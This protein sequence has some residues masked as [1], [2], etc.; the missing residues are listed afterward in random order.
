[1]NFGKLVV[2]VAWVALTFLAVF[3]FNRITGFDPGRI[4]VWLV[5]QAITVTAFLAGCPSRH[6]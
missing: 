3:A 1:M 6:C 4:P 5:D 2:L